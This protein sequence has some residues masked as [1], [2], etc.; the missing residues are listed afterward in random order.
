MVRFWVA[1]QAAPPSHASA[2]PAAIGANRLILTLPAL[3][4]V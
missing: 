2:S 4:S 3:R 1:D